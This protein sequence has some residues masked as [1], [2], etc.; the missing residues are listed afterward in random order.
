[1]FQ[2]EKI[3]PDNLTAE[4]LPMGWLVDSPA[5]WGTPGADRFAALELPFKAVPAGS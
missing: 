3:A 4:T 2:T 1:M 5:D